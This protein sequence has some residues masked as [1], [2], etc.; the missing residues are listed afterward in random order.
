MFFPEMQLAANE[1]ARV[2]KSGGRFSTGV[3]AAPDKNP[4]ITT[5]MGAIQR[6]TPVPPP[7]PGAPGIFRCAAPDLIAGLLRQAGLVRITEKEISRKVTYESADQYWT[8]MMEVAAP[9]VALMSQANEQARAAIKADV[10]GTLE[11]FAGA[12]SF[13]YGVRIISGSKA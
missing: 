6:H 10:F 9:V 7:A 8:M 1:I 2:L 3:W 5:M 11:R 13:D 4:W 12:I